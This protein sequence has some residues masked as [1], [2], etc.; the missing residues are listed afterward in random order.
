MLV[1]T[2]TSFVIIVSSQTMV[3]SDVPTTQP[4]PP[5]V[6]VKF[7][8]SVVDRL[9]NEAITGVEKIKEQGQTI[10]VKIKDVLGVNVSNQIADQLEQINDKL[11]RGEPVTINDQLRVVDMMRIQSKSILKMIYDMKGMNLP[12]QKEQAVNAL[13]NLSDQLFAKANQ[14]IDQADATPDPVWRQKLQELAASTERMG[15][16][17]GDWSKQI[18]AY[19]VEKSLFQIQMAEEYMKQA[20]SV[21]TLVEDYL[22][23][24]GN[25]RQFEETLKTMLCQLYD[26]HYSIGT[27]AKTLIEMPQPN[28]GGSAK[29]D[30]NKEKIISKAQTPKSAG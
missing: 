28:F 15:R 23:L 10:K 22:K 18:K 29:P 7:D 30:D 9:K 24:T 8:Q 11:E 3:F 2:L 12:E 27:F 25:Y 17:Y 13:S 14:I 21:L 6:D 20:D 1:R 19:Q 4:N 26:L 16:A 5:K